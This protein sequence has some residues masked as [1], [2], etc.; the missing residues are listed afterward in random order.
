M[1]LLQL[2]N[3][4]K[5]H[6]QVMLKRKIEELR[7]HGRH[8]FSLATTFGDASD[9]HGDPTY[10]LDPPIGY[11]TRSAQAVEPYMDQYHVIEANDENA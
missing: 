5:I 1:A 9:W 4:Y 6:S 3:V 2:I 11:S 8:P 10:L 7:E